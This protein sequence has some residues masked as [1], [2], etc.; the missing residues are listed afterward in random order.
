MS[1]LSLLHETYN[2]INAQPE[3]SQGLELYFH[4]NEKCHIEVVLDEHGNFR[5]A[6]S[7][8][9]CDEL[10]GKKKWD[11]ENTLVP[12]T[13]KSLTGRTSGAA[14]Y[15]LAE[16]IH[17]LAPNYSD[18]G[19]T[20]KCYYQEYLEQLS[21]WSRSDLSHPKANAVLN[22]ISKGE[23]LTD[24]IRSQLIYV[25]RSGANDL[26]VTD[27]K[28]QVEDVI[29]L[30]KPDSFYLTGLND[31]GQ[32]MVRWVVEAEGH[33][34]ST[35]WNDASLHRSWIDYETQL[36]EKKKGFCLV[37]GIEAY[38]TDTH[39]KGII[40]TKD[41]NGAK[42]ISSPTDKTYLTFQGRFLS[43]D[44][45]C[46][47]SFE[48]SQKAHNALRWLLQRQGRFIGTNSML[49]AWAVSGKAIP[50]PLSAT[51]EF[52]LDNFDEIVEKAVPI[53]NDR[54]EN[55]I[56][57]STD[58][59][60]RFAAKLN[61]YMSGYRA[62]LSDTDQISIM[63]IDSA[64]PGR[65]GITYYRETLPQEYL[66]RITQWHID[67][68]WPQRVVTEIPQTKG[69]PKTVLTW[70][71]SSPSPFSI[72]Q[73]VYGDT[74]KSNDSLKKN[75]YERII[76]CILE[77]R[78]IPVDFLNLS[79][80]RASNPAGQDRWE[81]ERALGVACSLYRGFHLR[82]PKIELRKEFIMAL[83]TTN[84]SRDYLYG[85]LLAIA[86]NI[87]S[88]ALSRTDE[89]RST[90]AE[91]LMQRFADRPFSTWRTIELSLRPYIN[92]LKAGDEKTR[93]FVYSRT[94]MLSRIHDLFVDSEQFKLDMK[95]SGE[96]LLGF[97]CQRLALE[98]KP[99]TTIST[100]TELTE[101]QGA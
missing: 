24:L 101:E 3:I 62:T 49:V 31:Q 85:R 67:F 35:T 84:T 36:T 69:K 11:G 47:V 76:P 50:D 88:Y 14:P 40:Q 73:V 23:L 87:E 16:K 18:F 64:T 46:S 78:A 63:A 39:P 92:R 70:P 95:L 9:K 6:R 90:S 42:L 79:V 100:Q 32:L 66:Q 48:A 10:G 45:A 58:L 59:G 97:H 93:G 77:Q 91:R 43:Q 83:D 60:N 82:H 75:F 15:P 72:M 65:M 8:I 52:D 26:L 71:V 98:K 7:L 81:W 29:G 56:D 13:P 25:Y 41:A 68:A 19:G 30:K 22:Y 80:A 53:D 20:K 5:R 28:K 4:K 51:V 61:A 86:D 27:W 2:Q 74:L 89:K 94:T 34:D 44:Q 17:Y 12:I 96:F 57:H 38:I 1:W 33:P 21:A 37:T 99:E 55:V 54:I